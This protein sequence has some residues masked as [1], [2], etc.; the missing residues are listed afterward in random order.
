M[1][2]ERWETLASVKKFDEKDS[3]ASPVFNEMGNDRRQQWAAP[4]VSQ[5]KEDSHAEQEHG[6]LQREEMIEGE[7]KW[8]QNESNDQAKPAG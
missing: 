1:K 7:N 2:G 8:L 5:G 3:G 4:P 6:V